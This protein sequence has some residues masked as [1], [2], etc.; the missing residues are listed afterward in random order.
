[1]DICIL[2][3]DTNTAATSLFLHDGGKRVT[4]VREF[5]QYP[6][7]PERFESVSQVLCHQGLTQ[8]HYWEVEWQGRWVDIAVAMRG[9]SRRANCHVSAFG[10]TDQSW[11]LYC[12]EDHYSAE[13]DSKR[14]K[15]P[16][17]ASLSRKVAVYLDWPGGTLS[18]YSMSIGSL[19]HLHTF[20]NNFTEPLYPGFG[21]EQEDSSVIICSKD[22]K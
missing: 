19:K 4:W 14:V 20:Y 21:M 22:G 6:N 8:R 15:I 1:M 17:P 10:K 3:F 13:H 11:C 5:Q 7:H 9:I 16:V 18:F 12:S 2:T